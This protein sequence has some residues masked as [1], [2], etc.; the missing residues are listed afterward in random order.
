MAFAGSIGLVL[1]VSKKNLYLGRS[2]EKIASDFLKSNGYKILS[3]NYRSK[4]GEIDIIAQDRKVICFIEVKTRASDKF[5]L[6]S[7]AVIGPKQRQISRVALAYLKEKG[8]FDKKARFDVVS[9]IDAQNSPKVTLI[10]NAFELDE[11]YGY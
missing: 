5:G 4:L 7:E 2:G 1:K 9:I 10:K 11:R 8:L 6:P 3:K